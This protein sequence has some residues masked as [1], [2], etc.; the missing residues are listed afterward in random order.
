MYSSNTIPRHTFGRLGIILA[1]YLLSSGCT[2]LT[3]QHELS[4][5]AIEYRSSEEAT[6]C[7]DL[8][9]RFDKIVKDHKTADSGATRIPGYPYL[10]TN[11]FLAS[12]RHELNRKQQLTFWLN[13]MAKIDIEKRQ[14]EYKNL[15]L[16]AQKVIASQGKNTLF[17]QFKSCSDWFQNQD[18]ANAQ[19]LHYLK[20]NAHVPSDYNSSMRWPGIHPF[21]NLFLRAGVADWHETVH[22]TFTNQKPSPTKPNPLLIR[23]GPEKFMSKQEKEKVLSDFKQATK[24]PLAAPDVDDRLMQKLFLTFAPIWEVET[25]TNA[26]L[27]GSPYWKST[28]Y[29]DVDTKASVQFTYPTY[30]RLNDD[31]LLQLNYV[32]WF[33]ARPKTNVFDLLGGQLDGLTW[34]VTLDTSGSP[35][36]YDAIHNCGCYHMLFHGPSLRPKPSTSKHIEPPLLLP[37]PSL[38]SVQQITIKLS[39]RDHQIQAVFSEKDT[40]TD[41]PYTFKPYEE[42]LVLQTPNGHQNLFNEKGFISGTERA[43]RFFFWPTGVANAGAMRQKG[44]HVTAFISERHFDDPRLIEELFIRR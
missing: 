42:L 8:Y 39:A 4:A 24:N 28:Q 5:Q 6:Y 19:S 36:L 16:I 35:L 18:M 29:P 40:T 38:S 33:K 20:E 34:R 44:R 26:D 43:E 37:A 30:T 12:F 11:R 13:E 1:I 2:T 25:K 15:P 22:K 14:I 7:L 41:I 32:I 31:S 23:Y 27:I 17:D 9:Q 3:T 10:R 21:V